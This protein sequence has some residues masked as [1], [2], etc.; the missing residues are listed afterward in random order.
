MFATDFKGK[1]FGTYVHFAGTFYVLCGSREC[2]KRLHS[3]YKTDAIIKINDPYNFA[4]TISSYI[5][6][7]SVGLTGDCIYKENP[8]I[9]NVGSDEFARAAEGMLIGPNGP[10]VE[11]ITALAERQWTDDAYFVKREKEYR[12]DW[13][14][15][16]LW[17]VPRCERFIDIVCPEARQFCE[18]AEPSF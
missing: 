5:P 9:R 17:K 4:T 10:T 16:M 8:F 13:E 11:Q 7:F 12:D 14:A 2:S 6:G 3:K 18:R 1:T 15:R